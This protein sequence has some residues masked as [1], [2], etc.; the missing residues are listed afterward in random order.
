MSFSTT[1]LLFPK[2]VK[3]LFSIQYPTRTQIRQEMQGLQGRSQVTTLQAKTL[4]RETKDLTNS[5]ICHAQ[6]QIRTMYKASM[7]TPA[8]YCLKN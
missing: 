3:S 8:T 1:I 4:I 5:H 2:Y 7:E 6:L